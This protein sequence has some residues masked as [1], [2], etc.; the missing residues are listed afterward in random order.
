MISIILFAFAAFF[1]AVI[2]TL[3][4]HYERSVFAK[5]KQSFWNRQYS[6]KNKK[7]L[8]SA[9]DAWHVAKFLQLCC[10]TACALTPKLNIEWH[11]T[12]A[13]MSIVWYLVFE[14]FYSKLLVT[15]LK[16]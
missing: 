2:D 5:L 8:G 9:F 16:K 1:T 6:W 12:V 7:I 14:G 4:F 13:I 10:F 3:Q 15:K 11:Y